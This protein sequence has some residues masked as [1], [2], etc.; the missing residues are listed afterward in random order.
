MNIKQFIALV[1]KDADTPQIT[2]GYRGERLTTCKADN[3]I[4]LQAFARYK[5]QCVRAISPDTYEIEIASTDPQPI[6]ED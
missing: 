5:V 6:I 1:Y 3:E 4:I 2:I